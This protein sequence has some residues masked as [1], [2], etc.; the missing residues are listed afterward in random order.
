M[1][2]IKPS[3]GGSFS[4][5]GR[6]VTFLLLDIF[7]SIL[8]VCW[9]VRLGTEPTVLQGPYV[10]D[11]PRYSYRYEEQSRFRNNRRVYLLI[12]NTIIESFLFAILTFAILQFVRH[13]YHAGAL[14]VVFL[15]QT[16]YW[17]VAFAVGMTVSSYI[18]ITLGGAIM[19]L[20]V[21]WDIYLLIM[22]RRQKKPT[23]GFVEVDEGGASEN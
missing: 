14:L 3:A 7:F 4:P 2:T 19:G 21:V 5:K 11:K 22:Y 16:A 6:K 13:R 12:A 9:T 23:A 15:I 17:I 8:L 10:G 18:N 20:C 1:D